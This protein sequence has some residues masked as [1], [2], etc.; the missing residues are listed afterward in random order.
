MT[1]LLTRMRQIANREGFDIEVTRK[2]KPL[3]NLRKNGVLGPY[4]FQKKLADNRTVDKWRTN[5]FE[6]THPGYS[7]NVLKGDGKIAVGQTLLRTVR[8]AYTND[9]A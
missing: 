9:P 1:M 3:K 8:E 5:R 2:A 7:C 6:L 4:T